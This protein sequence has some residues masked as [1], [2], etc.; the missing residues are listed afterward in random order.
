MLGV[1]T[2]GSTGVGVGA[3][4]GGGAVV[5]VVVVVVPG[6]GGLVTDGRTTG[7]AVAALLPDPEFA[8]SSMVLVG[9]GVGVGFLATT[10]HA[11]N[12]ADATTVITIG[13]ANVRR[14]A[15]ADM[16]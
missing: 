6:I 7:V 16:R 15:R 8:P 12:E 4:T 11:P 1:G 2:G 5:V 9:A 3:T 14:G 10:R 13:E